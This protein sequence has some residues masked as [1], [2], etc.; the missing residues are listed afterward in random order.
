[1]THGGMNPGSL[2]VHALRVTTS[3]STPGNIAVAAFIAVGLYANVIDDPYKYIDHFIPDRRIRFP[4]SDGML[5]EWLHT[6]N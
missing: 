5:A 6:S 3:D 4:T 1:M 2:Y